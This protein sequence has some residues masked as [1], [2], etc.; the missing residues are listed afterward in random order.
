MASYLTKTLE[1][2]SS[3]H[4]DLIS[5]LLLWSNELR[6]FVPQE[7]MRRRRL[8]RSCFVVFKAFTGL[9]L[10][11]RR[12]YLK[13]VVYI[14]EGLRNIEHFTNIEPASVLIVGSWAEA[15][16][17]KSIGFKFCWSFPI[18]CSAILA[19]IYQFDPFLRY[20]SILWRRALKLGKKKFVILYE[21][22]Q[23]LGGFFAAITKHSLV[24]INCKAICAQHGYFPASGRFSIIDGSFTEYNF[25][26]DD[27]SIVKI[28]CDPLKTYVIGP[29][30]HQRPVC[31]KLNKVIFVGPGASS[32]WPGS[33]YDGMNEYSHIINYYLKVISSI[34]TRMQS[35]VTYRPHPSELIDK[36]ISKTLRNQFKN[37]EYPKKKEILAGDR[38][39]FVG[40]FSSLLFEAFYCGHVVV[41]LDICKGTTAALNTNLIFKVG[42]EKLAAEHIS[43]LLVAKPPAFSQPALAHHSFHSAIKEISS[44]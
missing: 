35:V 39:I 16:Y 11:P 33:N 43:A 42:E 37:I 14:L 25:V 19:K 29:Q 38:H 17:A 3:L 23:P 18:E 13:D 27:H 2:W 28:N 12:S 9:L 31:E 34:E 1:E 8:E 40:A 30:L 6:T 24:N 15:K 7:A 36:E 44:G 22:T 41:V 32:R 26:W 21:D 5:R 4:N 10:I 20:H